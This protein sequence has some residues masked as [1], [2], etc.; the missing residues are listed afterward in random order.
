MGTSLVLTTSEGSATFTVATAGHLRTAGQYWES[1]HVP[2]AEYKQ[3]EIEVPSR[4]G[5]DIKQH[6]FRNRP[7]SATVV[8]V[9]ASEQTCNDNFNTVRSA[10]EQ[11]AITAT[12]PNDRDYASCYLASM[13]P[14]GTPKDSGHSTYFLN[15]D[16]TLNQKRPT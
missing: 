8:F 6:G 7:I 5:V 1:Y 9:A 13:I 10:I 12:I 14:S 16:I 4:D 3:Q 2:S 15:V 11:V